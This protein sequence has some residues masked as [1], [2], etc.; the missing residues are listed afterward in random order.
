MI[1]EEI[2]VKAIKSQN[3][4]FLK[5]PLKIFLYLEGAPIYNRNDHLHRQSL[6]IY[7]ITQ[8]LLR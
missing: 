2:F 3:T 4:Y 5:F 8:R 6:F 7:T 1:Y